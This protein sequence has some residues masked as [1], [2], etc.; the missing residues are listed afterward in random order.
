M[1][2]PSKPELPAAVDEDQRFALALR[3]EGRPRGEILGR[4]VDE[5]GL[6]EERAKELVET[7]PERPEFA[8][9]ERTPEAPVE[10]ASA[11]ARGNG[12]RIIGISVPVCLA[13]VVLAAGA[14]RPWYGY[15]L[16]VIGIVVAIAG[17]LQ[18][19]TGEEVSSTSGKPPA[20]DA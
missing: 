9:P 15:L 14:H 8:P 7:L 18:V 6:S 13:G 19:L 3:S 12:L 11:R 2:E 10:S 5:R 16:V 4:L 1:S 17:L 20:R